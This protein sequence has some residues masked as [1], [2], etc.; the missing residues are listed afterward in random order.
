MCYYYSLFIYFSYRQNFLWI[1]EFQRI[2][3]QNGIASTDI[4][5]CQMDGGVSF[6]DHLIK[7][8]IK[9]SL[10]LP[11]QNYTFFTTVC[12]LKCKMVWTVFSR[13][14]FK[15]M[16]YHKYIATPLGCSA[17]LNFKMCPVHMLAEIDRI[18]EYLRVIEICQLIAVYKYY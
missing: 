15:K 7:S 12:I 5:E 13:L 6:V 1:I 11:Y 9:S 16:F 8:I 17:C 2:P 10:L 3:L 14:Q 4:T 18:I